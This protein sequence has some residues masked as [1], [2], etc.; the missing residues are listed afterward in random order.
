MMWHSSALSFPKYPYV[1]A[2]RAV[3]SSSLSVGLRREDPA[4]L[5]ERRAP[6]TPAAVYRLVRNG[7]QVVVQGCDR[8]VFSDNEYVSVS[9]IT[10]TTMYGGHANISDQAG[11]NIGRSLESC[12]IILGIKEV[13]LNELLTSQ[14]DNQPRTHLMF[15]HTAKGQKYNLP[16]LARFLES[17]QNPRLID[18][19]QLT[20]Q[21]GKRTVAFGFFAGSTGVIEGL[22]ASALDLLSIGI[23]SPFLVSFSLSLRPRSHS[24]HFI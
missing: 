24:V 11:A 10:V 17:P 21:N 20:D 13:P 7:V 22:S 18:Y 5:W 2:R 9:P 14:V 15:S 16:L 19:E 3:S 4:R 6:L 8:R 12:S 1:L 23:A